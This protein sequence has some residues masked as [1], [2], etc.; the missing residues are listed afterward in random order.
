MNLEFGD[1]TLFLFG[2]GMTFN[3]TK[4]GT[5]DIRE[6]VEKAWKNR[7][8]KKSLDD[9]LKEILDER[10]F[11][12]NIRDNT[13]KAF[14]DKRMEAYWFIMRYIEGRRAFIALKDS[15]IGC[16][17]TPVP[18]EYVYFVRL[19]LGKKCSPYV[20]TTNWD[21]LL[22]VAFHQAGLQVTVLF[23]GAQSDR[24]WNKVIPLD[25]QL[26]VNE[27]RENNRVIVVKLHGTVSNAFSVMGSLD[28][29]EDLT[30]LKRTA[31]ERLF[32][33]HSQLVTVGWS[34]SD[35]DIIKVINNVGVDRPT[36]WAVSNKP[37][38]DESNLQKYLNFNRDNCYD[39]YL[40]ST[41][42]NWLNAK[43]EEMEIPLLVDE[44]RFFVSSEE[45]DRPIETFRG[46]RTD[47]KYKKAL[48][49]RM[50]C[51]KNDYDEIYTPMA[52]EKE[53]GENQIL[54]HKSIPVL[55]VHAANQKEI[56]GSFT[57]A[58]EFFFS[59]L[60]SKSEYEHIFYN[61]TNSICPPYS[62]LDLPYPG[63][64]PF[65]AHSKDVSHIVR[66]AEAIQQAGFRGAEPSMVM[67]E[68]Q[69]TAGHLQDKNVV[70]LGGPDSNRWVL[71]AAMLRE[72]QWEHDLGIARLPL[73][74]WYTLPD[75][76]YR[77]DSDT[78]WQDIVNPTNNADK[79]DPVPNPIR[80]F[81]KKQLKDDPEWQHCGM[82]LVFPNPFVS[83]DKK[84]WIAI[85]AGLMNTGTQA[86]LLA[87][88]DIIS[89]KINTQKFVVSNESENEWAYALLIKASMG[90][91][92]KG[93]ENKSLDLSK[94][95][96]GP[97]PHTDGRW[98]PSYIITEYM[99]LDE[100]GNWLLD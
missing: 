59:P 83:E 97:I 74:M 67:N 23:G 94:E 69:V 95:L 72:C 80:E 91:E 70:L 63:D 43:C 79:K 48:A 73:R 13:N 66:L 6:T 44:K 21:E 26:P 30:R 47:P 25:T 35:L 32:K 58:T 90:Y 53:S 86:A 84:C 42:D 50:R 41:A 10:N 75:K 51:Y 87:F 22:E 2:S 9:V 33:W 89:G 82:V 4:T 76:T 100:N 62:I 3:A 7:N 71:L 31:L 39:N 52:P 34:A 54:Q 8:E 85:L 20:V 15:R 29:I 88:A 68:L 78:L 46:C 17:W 57:R 81:T 45:Y 28:D 18:P 12:Q 16:P 64:Y 55:I 56:P 38:H 27:L 11:S 49:Q 92:N 61:R 99:R 1:E 37:L 96:T 14:K 98:N 36:L 65:A 77:A 19:M 93:F 40:E 24:V 60:L 5:E